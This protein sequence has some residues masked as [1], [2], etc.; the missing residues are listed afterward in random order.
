MSKYIEKYPWLRCTNLYTGKLYTDRDAMDDMLEQAPGWE[1]AFGEMFC[2]EMDTVIKAANLQDEFFI[3]QLKEKFGALRVYVSHKT[4]EIADILR[5]YEAISSHVCIEC[6][7]P[8][9]P[10]T[11]GGWICPMCEDCFCNRKHRT[12]TKKQYEEATKGSDSKIVEEIIY[13]VWDP[14]IHKPHDEGTTIKQDISQTVKAVRDK[15]SQ[16]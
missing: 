5:K 15:W 14:K 12:Y 4:K 9:V 1:K 10:M 13:T 16:K 3:A 2:E 7:K 8:D 11:Y 6:G